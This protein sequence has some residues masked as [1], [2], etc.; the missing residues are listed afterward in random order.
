MTKIGQGVKSKQEEGEVPYT[1][2]GMAKTAD[3]KTYLIM[4]LKVSGFEILSRKVV[5]RIENYAEAV[6]H[7]QILSATYCMNFVNQKIG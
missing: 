4:E 5:K 1:A 3:N 2:F 6:Q 7:F